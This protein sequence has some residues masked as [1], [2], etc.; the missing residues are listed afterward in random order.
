MILLR[1]PFTQP[2][3]VRDVSLQKHNLDDLKGHACERLAAWQLCDVGTAYCVGIFPP[4]MLPTPALKERARA[5]VEVRV[6]T[7]D[8]DAVY[9]S[10]STCRSACPFVPRIHT[11]LLDSCQLVLGLGHALAPSSSHSRSAARASE[12]GPNPVRRRCDL[13]AASR[14]PTDVLAIPVLTRLVARAITSCD[15]RPASRAMGS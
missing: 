3:D 10:R 14:E 4:A 12:C 13:V 6:V 5:S 2:L 15:P 1:A 9:E 7:D 8:P 11:E